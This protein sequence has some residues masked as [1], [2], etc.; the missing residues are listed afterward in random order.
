[1]TEI[2]L[3]VAASIVG[4]LASGYL[5]R[6]VVARP[7]EDPDV[8]VVAGRIRAVADGF[9]RR[10][11]GVSSALAAACGG[12][13]FL[14]YGLLRR[15]GDAYPAPAL[16]L[17]VWLTTSFAAGAASAIAAGKV[18]T[19]VCTRT[20]SRAAL[21]ARS[22][23]DHA[24]RVGI[25]GGAASALFLSAMSLLGP[26]VFYA[27]VFAYKSK[28]F[29]EPAAALAIA[30]AIP[31]MIMGYAFGAAFVGLLAELGG[32][33]FG[34][35]ADLGADT[36]AREEGLGEDD[37]ANPAAIP[38]LAGDAAGDAAGRS[39]G[40]LAST[41]AEN[42]G[43][44]LL[45]AMVYRDNP[46]IT[47]AIAVT[48]FPLVTR[49]FG[50]AAAIFGVMVVRTDDRE[51]P[52]NAIARGLYVTAV[53]HFVAMVGAAK[54]L[55]GDHWL[56]LSGAGA[57]G[58][59]TTIGLFY[60]S[61]YS[62]E[63][64]HRPVREL[65]DA[66][67]AGPA[68]TLL[69][70]LTAGIESA[71]VAIAI[72]ASSAACAYALGARTHLTH[73]GLYG[74]AIAAMGMLGS[75]GYVLGADAFGAIADIA[76]G[77]VEMTIGRERPDVRGR[78]VMLDA[79]GNTAKAF[80]KVY[81]ASVAAVAAPL[82]V[83]AFVDE[84]RR[85]A[86]MA[87]GKGPGAFASQP[88]V[89]RL[90]S[91]EVLLGVLMGLLLVAW[92]GARCLKGVVRTSRRILDE[93]RRQL[94]GRPLGSRSDAPG[95]ARAGSNA[96]PD[97]EACVEVA[98]RAALRQMIAPAVAATATPV[99][100][101]LGLR[102]ARTHDNPLAV[103]DS[104]AALITAGTIAGVLGSLLLGNAGG[105]WDNAKKYIATGAH[106]G[107]YLVDESGARVD[108]PTYGAAQVGDAVGDPLKDVAAPVIHVLAKLLPLV[109]L[110]FLPFF[111]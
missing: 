58:V 77:V 111:S 100:F 76:R 61:Q 86:A 20:A 50:V 43:A 32:G 27:A 16:E 105:A 14:A 78:A 103:T 25:R 59:A 60:L 79:V 38:D 41:T 24:L 89:L 44:M 67:R 73:G 48:L 74:L 107:R 64:R 81:V 70:G 106:G 31:Q 75:S 91:P 88:L 30:P 28:L 97:Y 19:W 11:S 52:L 90:D 42:L 13:I 57:L 92:I 96:L 80:T 49:S 101:G 109:A 56:L 10:W 62:V 23:A 95:L 26:T 102:F 83:A 22:S 37:P 53:L 45:G 85:R 40:V 5:G 39:A 9:Y 104:V 21:A 93:A 66:S 108:N 87:A 51:D 2:A 72:T 110:V 82:L 65:A 84:S 3:I 69:Y 35:A 71:V 7:I 15:A 34:K 18:T 29:A 46:S 1:M 99:A 63:P 98:A 6:W 94:R 12:A 54:W 17:G 36:A 8:A 68:L 4:L 55:L 33:T 47:S